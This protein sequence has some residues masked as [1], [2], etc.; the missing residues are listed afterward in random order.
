[1]A[2]LPREAISVP[3]S[4]EAES[5]YDHYIAPLGSNKLTTM[6]AP[7]I[8]NWNEVFPDYHRSFT[9]INGLVAAGKKFQTLGIMNTGWTDFGQTLY[10][11]SLPGLAFGAVAGWQSES[12]DTNRFFNDYCAQTYPAAVAPEVAAALEELSTVEQMF[13]A[14]LGDGTQYAFWKDPLEPGLLSRVEKRQDSCRQARLLA[15]TAQERLSRAI[16]LAPSDPTLNSLM[17]AA[18]LFDYMGMKNLYAVEWAGYFR[19]LQEN[20]DQQS[21]QLYI[22]QEMNAEDHGML[23][24]L[25][26]AVTGLREPYRAAW[27]EESTPYRLETAMARWDAESRFWLDTWGRVHQ[28]LRSHKKGEPFPSIDVL[29]ARR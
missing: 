11:Q 3:W 16:T 17:I 26:D 18:R 20:P 29:R 10:R 8:W 27:L 15:E 1:V 7:G 4:Y 2:R 25:L 12:V 19:Q 23:S 9:D 6:V 21:V 14:I 24:D 28:I 22:G 13:E 5:N